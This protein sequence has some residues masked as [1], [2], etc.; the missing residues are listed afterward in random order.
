MNPSIT[1]KGHLLYDL[2]R[3]MSKGLFINDA[4]KEDKKN[5]KQKNM[6][7]FR[8]IGNVNYVIDE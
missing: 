4:I 5:K 6:K 8:E 3:M 2:L 1:H 7:I